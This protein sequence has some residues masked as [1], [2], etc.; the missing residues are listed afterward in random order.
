[1]IN[2]SVG[3]F[4]EIFSI[5]SVFAFSS[6]QHVPA[7][8]PPSTYWENVN[9]FATDALFEMGASA[10]KLYYIINGITFYDTRIKTYNSELCGVD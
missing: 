10:V 3:I 9:F 5:L 4:F 2:G 7:F 8:V 1:M 6:S